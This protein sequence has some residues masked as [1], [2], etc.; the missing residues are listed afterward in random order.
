[1]SLGPLPQLSLP[2]YR[3]RH[4]FT[5]R[6]RLAVF[7]GFW[8][9]YLYFYHAVLQQ[10]MVVTAVFAGSFLLT[11][12][13]YYWIL[14]DRHIIPAVL[15]EVV[16]DLVTITAV[17]YITEGPYS[18][19]F[20]LYLFYI[21]AA[22]IFYNH[23]LALYIALA[24]AAVYGAFLWLCHAGFIPPLIVDWQDAVPPETHS[25]QY[26]FLFMLIFAILAVYGVKVASYFSRKRER[27][28][29]S[30]NKELSALAHMV[31]TVRSSISLE[32][33]LRQVLQGLEGGLDLKL[34]VLV[35][36]DWE[37]NK[38]R[39]LAPA[40]HLIA[41]QVLALIGGY[42]EKARF[43]IDVPDN[44]ALNSLL[45][46]KVIFRNRL[47][48]ILT[49]LQ[50]EPP[51][52]LIE[53]AEKI[54]G[55]RKLVG[56]PLVAEEKLLGALVGFSSLAR[57]DD[58][59]VRTLEAFANQAALIIE[60][61]MLIHQLKKA[62]ENLKEANRVKSE[63]LAT[64][65][66]ELRTPLTAIIGFSELLLEGVMGELTEEQKESLQEI[67][68]NGALLLEMINNLLDLAKVEA[69]KMGVETETFHLP[70]L[71]KRLTQTIHSL[72]Q[73]KGQSL[74]V[75]CPGDVPF[76]V[77]DEKKVQQI[78][79]NLL[80][81]AI[82]FTPEKGKIRLA[83]RHYNGEGWEKNAPWVAK[84]PDKSSYQ[85]GAFEVTVAD[86]GIGIARDKLGKI[87]E[88]FSQ[89]DSSI[90]RIHGGTGLGLALAKQLTELQ[91]GVVWAE[92]ELGEGTQFTVV[93][94][95]VVLVY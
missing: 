59:S 13:A 28:L 36:F 25:P 93:L 20:T 61:A 27:M 52:G 38:V 48:E 16:A 10:L 37:R 73:R 33:I 43:P 47:S 81:N 45:D 88:M 7:I 22:G 54:I 3:D 26:H 82:K 50:P 31:A 51:A 63:F 24:S 64:M 76:M 85:K 42:A 11:T 35:I 29:E 58:P 40:E 77:A 67:V 49:G 80:S 57:I 72:V 75:D 55:F 65:S 12:L 95:A 5:A 30:R 17:I 6:L 56:V 68:N 91:H 69:G 21:F 60:A 14:R 74:E 44:S 87:F 4:L 94:P 18:D 66:H 78:L 8:C 2:E 62:N 34:F 90:T 23:V 46:H 83:L 89:A 39:M 41:R 86:T 19:F 92:S 70:D 84:I 9:L 15:T 53:A 71:L 79:L 32:K 1:M